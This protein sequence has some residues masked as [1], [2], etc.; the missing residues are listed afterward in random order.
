MCV[1]CSWLSHERQDRFLSHVSTFFI[2]RYTILFR[3]RICQLTTEPASKNKR[4][5]V[6]SVV[7]IFLQAVLKMS[8]KVITSVY[9]YVGLKHSRVLQ[10]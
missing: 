10:Q 7:N 9:L 2:Q 4:Q 5:R 8:V 6:T 3:L 1:V